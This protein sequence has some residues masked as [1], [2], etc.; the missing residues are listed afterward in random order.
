M[1]ILLLIFAPM[2]LFQIPDLI[3]NKYW[4]ELIAYSVFY[5]AALVLSLLYVLDVNIPSPIA[6]VKY[7]IE[8]VLNL[9]Y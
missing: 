1:I 7:I 8:D 2:A 3:K 5:T 6:G 9:K 4:K